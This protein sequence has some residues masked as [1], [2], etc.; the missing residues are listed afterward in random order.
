MLCLPCFLA[1]APAARPSSESPPSSI[2]SVADL[3]H[4]SQAQCAPSTRIIYES[5][6]FI[7][8]KPHHSITHHTSLPFFVSLIS[9]L[10]AF[11]YHHVCLPLWFSQH[12][13]IAVSR[14][15]GPPC[16][17]PPL[18]LHPRRQVLPVQPGSG[19]N[20]NTGC[21]ANT[22]NTGT[23]SISKIATSVLLHEWYIKDIKDCQWWYS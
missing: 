9:L 6:K 16:Y 11:S 13:R 7:S 2:W 3:T 5:Y 10:F 1:L 21:M 20:R 12:G 19:I 14:S 23:R 18:P 4:K 22:G 15:P 8:Y 17:R